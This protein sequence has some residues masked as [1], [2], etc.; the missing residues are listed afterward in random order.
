MKHAIHI[1]LAAALVSLPHFAMAAADDYVTFSAGAEATTGKYGGTERTNI[2]Y[3]PFT[4]KYETGLW[5]YKLT[6]PY[7]SVTAPSNAVVIDA[8]GGQ[9]I[10]ATGPRHTDSGLGDVVASAF[11]TALNPAKASLGI[12]LGVKVKFGTA[13]HAKGLGTG[14]ND[15]SLQADLYKRFGAFTPFGTIGYRWYGDPPEV[16]LLNAFFGT[17]GGTY[18]ISQSRTAGLAYDF[19][20]PIV[21]GGGRVSELTAYFSQY[22]SKNW[23]LQVYTIAGFANASPDFGAGATLS[24]TY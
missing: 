1:A 11:Y 16:N 21:A 24:Y 8:E 12:D 19:R 13:D 3:V 17:V 6:V 4:G 5:T 23:K 14:E 22:Y 2:Y 9:V 10:S 18:R 20:D 7:V 15:Y